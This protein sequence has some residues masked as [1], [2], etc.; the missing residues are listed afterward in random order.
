MP[1]VAGLVEFC[2]QVTFR[3]PLVRSAIYRSASTE[4][5]REAHQALAE[6]TDAQLDPIGVHGTLPRPHPGPMRKV[7]A[8]LERC[9]ERAQ[10]RGGLAAAAAFLERSAALTLDSGRRAGRA[11]AAARVM[12]QSGAF[13]AAQRLLATAEAGPLDGLAARRGRGAARTDRIRVQ[14]R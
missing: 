10:A 3:H 9:A 11:L 6:A 13:D 2:V 4:Q 8:E 14:P 5:R 1:R 7:A 12:A